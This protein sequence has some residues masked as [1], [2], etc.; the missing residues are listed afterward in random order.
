[1]RATFVMDA[2]AASA[3]S[4][5]QCAFC[6]IAGKE[7]ESCIVFEDRC[8]LAFLDHRPL[9]LGHCLLI[10]KAHYGTL[11]DLPE[12]LVHDLFRNAQ[13]L[14]QA[15]ETSQR[16]EGSLLAVNNRV[17]QSVPHFHIHIVPRRK[18]D[19]LKGFFWPRRKYQD[20]AE[21]HATQEAIC[22][23]LRELREVDA[24]RASSASA[25]GGSP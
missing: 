20:A 11:S 22:S 4:K 2:L 23:A 8:S 3:K 6:R 10:P 19:G 21:M 25:R 16:A 9:F 24:A 17:S 14:A 15:V 7:V 12:E 5:E 1:M 13:L 18:G